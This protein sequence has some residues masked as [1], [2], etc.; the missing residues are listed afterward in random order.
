MEWYPHLRNLESPHQHLVSFSHTQGRW[1]SEAK[2][3]RASARKENPEALHSRDC[4]AARDWGLLQVQA[5][6]P[7]LLPQTPTHLVLRVGPRDLHPLMSP[8]SDSE[9]DGLQRTESLVSR[10]MKWWPGRRA[11]CPVLFL[12]HEYA[13]A[14]M[15]VA[16]YHS[17]GIS[18][19]PCYNSLGPRINL[20]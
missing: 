14:R 20:P 19:I 3:H 10:W 4:P 15:K 17:R 8:L 6:R 7:G 9:E 12:V 11:I 5:P 2:T 16:F 1:N 13:R 18:M